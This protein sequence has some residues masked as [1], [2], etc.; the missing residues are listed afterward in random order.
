MGSKKYLSFQRVCTECY[1][2]QCTQRAIFH[3]SLLL[4]KM[5]T[6]S[7]VAV[8]ISLFLF[9]LLFSLL[10]FQYKNFVFFDSLFYHWLITPAHITQLHSIPL[11]ASHHK[12]S[13]RWGW[14][15]E[16]AGSSDC[17]SH[18]ESPPVIQKLTYKHI[19]T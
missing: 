10:I 6:L 2:H 8:F 9:S 16:S 17:R 4:S 12:N 19:Y 3:L 11:I 15:E 14:K 13:I 7:L 5:D 18:C 1:P